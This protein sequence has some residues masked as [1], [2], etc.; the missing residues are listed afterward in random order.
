MARQP[1]SLALHDRDA[2]P[3]EE[4]AV[5][6]DHRSWA[7]DTASGRPKFAVVLFADEARSAPVQIA[8]MDLLSVTTLP[9]SKG[10][11]KQLLDTFTAAMH[12]DLILIETLGQL[13][14]LETA[15]GDGTPLHLPRTAPT[16]K[17]EETRTYEVL[18][19]ED[20]IRA[21][22]AANAKGAVFETSL[23]SRRERG[24]NLISTCLNRLIGLVGIDLGEAE[25]SDLRAIG[26]I[27]LKTTEPGAAAGEE[28]GEV[29]SRRDDGSPRRIAQG[30][31]KAT[32][33]K[34]QEA[35]SSFETR[36]KA[37][38]GSSINTS[39]IVRLRALIQIILAHAQPIS[40]DRSP[41]QILPVYT[42]EG[43]DW[44]RLI[45]RLLIQHFGASRALQDLEV[46]PDDSE[47]LR[48]IEYL[49]LA[50]WAGAAA[51]RA[52]LSIPRARSLVGPLTGLLATLRAQTEAILSAVPADKT[53][54][55]TICAKLDER[56][57]ARLG[58][59]GRG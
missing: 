38:Q 21:R 55:D 49:A 45:G 15:E 37:M 41:G 51:H 5:H 59:E 39:E 32:A 25:E 54:F 52:V 46:E 57:A 44:P 6:P 22:T 29:P 31:S 17:S 58:L 28:R 4:L 43:H 9:P 1:I 27:D 40:G 53:Y 33:R 18:S 12:E 13:E 35:V 2:A 42:A 19:Y 26:S 34:F 48:V 10:R 30:Q 16:E 47:Q 56:F 7:V 36:C 3:L 23:G 50:N 20:Y 8:D 24:S 14:A 11:K